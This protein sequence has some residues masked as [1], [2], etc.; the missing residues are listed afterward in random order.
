MDQITKSPPKKLASLLSPDFETPPP[1]I[2][3]PADKGAIS[4]E[5]F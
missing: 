1:Q 2:A 3:W 5:L 4:L